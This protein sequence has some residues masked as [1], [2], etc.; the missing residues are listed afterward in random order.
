MAM[1]KGA[2][3]VA[4]QLVTQLAE[5]SLT[6]ALAESCTGG[7]AAKHITDVPGS[8]AIFEC[9]LVTYSNASKMALLGVPEALL[10]ADGAVS[11]SVVEAMAKGALAASGADLAGAV[12][13]IA[14]PGGGSPEKPVGTVWFGW[15]SRTGVCR[16]RRILFDGDRDRV[17][18]QS[19]EALLQGLLDLTTMALRDTES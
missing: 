7:W 17:R 15:A 6:L 14:G 3:A 8:S 9:G 5:A 4:G 11:Q 16:S 12:S 13:G 18:L 1:A 10:E 2:E 19:V